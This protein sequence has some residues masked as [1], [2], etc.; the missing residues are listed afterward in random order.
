MKKHLYIVALLISALVV[1]QQTPAPKQ[2]Q[3]YT[4]TNAKAHIGNGTVIN[5]AKLII[6]DGKI[7]FIG[8][9]NSSIANRG[10]VIDAKGQNIYPGFIAPNTT[11]GLAEIDA[12]RASR[13]DKEV[14]TMNPH[15]RSLIAYNAE[16]K[17]I[18]T[19]RPNGILIAQ[20]TP[21]GG[22]ISG[23]SSIVQLDA[24]NWED[25][26]IKA[27]D[28][29]HINWPEVFIRT[30]N[31]L[32]GKDATCTANKDYNKQIYELDI[33]FRDSRAYNAARAPIKNLPFKSMKG[34][35]RG[36]KKL[37]IHVND[38]KGIIDAIK[39]SKGHKIKDVVIVGGLD[40]NRTIPILKHFNIPVLLKRIHSNPVNDYDDYDAIY[41]LAKTLTDAGILVGLESSG[42]MERMQTRNLPFYAGTCAAFGMLQKEAL[43]LITLNTAK[44]LGIDKAYGSLEL[45]KSATLII[46]DGDALDM[47]GNKITHAFIDGRKIS[48]ESHQTE[49]YKR[50]SEKYKSEQFA[51]KTPSKTEKKDWRDVFANDTSST[52]STKI[53]NKIKNPLFYQNEAPSTKKESWLKRLFKNDKKEEN[54][55]HKSKKNKHYPTKAEKEKKTITKKN[56]KVKKETAPVENATP[57]NNDKKSWKWIFK[58]T[59][60]EK[61]NE[62]E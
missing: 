20:T 5:E 27:D 4:I 62:N 35:F 40:A 59:N 30:H 23:T 7:V 17:V 47:K 57:T 16:S 60:R 45:G 28:G 61:N 19:M 48:L 56:K 3:A 51:V 18:E 21:R 46:S 1:A 52:N 8:A 38:E 54:S 43:Q 41:K 9:R 34:L 44:I 32:A 10:I 39:F 33:F 55:T 29:I 49:L 50:Y 13:D 31:W 2:T 53:N 11:L 15:I 37:F 25:A 42:P 58:N 12:V 36:Q 14:G 26:V 24:W 22:R 6:Q